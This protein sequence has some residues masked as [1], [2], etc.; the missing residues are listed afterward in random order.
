MCAGAMWLTCV[1][2]SNSSNTYELHD[3]DDPFTGEESETQRG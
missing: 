3:Y 2:P 1:I